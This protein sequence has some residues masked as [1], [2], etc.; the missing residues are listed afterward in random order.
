MRVR[1]NRKRILAKLA[2]DKKYIW[3]VT[4]FMIKAEMAAK[5]RRRIR[6]IVDATF[7]DLK[8]VYVQS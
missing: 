8:G 1:D 7:A 2:H 6:E 3:Y 4:P 5:T